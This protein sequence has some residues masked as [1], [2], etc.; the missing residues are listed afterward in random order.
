MIYA[1]LNLQKEKLGIK[2]FNIIEVISIACLESLKTT[3]TR[4]KE[5]AIIYQCVQDGE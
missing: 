3:I 2:R 5:N 1:T 4:E